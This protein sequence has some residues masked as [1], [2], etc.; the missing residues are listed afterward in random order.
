MTDYA[1][2]Y[3]MRSLTQFTV[4][5]WM[6]TSATNKGTPFSYA[7]PGQANELL[8]YNHNAFVLCIGGD[9]R[10]VDESANDGRWHHICVTWRN[11][12]G[13]WQ[14]Y[15]DGELHSHTRGLRKGYTIQGG[16]SLVLGQDQDSVGGAF[17]SSQS[18][19]GTLTNVNVWSYFLS[20][21]TIKSM[22]RSCLSGVGNVYEW[23]DFIYGVKG[24]TG[25][26]IPSSCSPLSTQGWLLCGA[27]HT[28]FNLC[29]KNMA[30]LSKTIVNLKSDNGNCE[31]LT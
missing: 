26:V 16:A 3:G 4:C 21:D 10:Y 6:N 11:S 1:N 2:V 23:S 8:L 14:F 30:S 20:P 17:D 5:L 13:V 9:S 18:F 24:N 22:S 15:K 28:V 31:G 7:V 19:Q 12:D 27:R 29:E 25:I